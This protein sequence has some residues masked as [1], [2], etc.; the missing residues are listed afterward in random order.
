MNLSIDYLSMLTPA[1]RVGPSVP[2]D[3]LDA[4]LAKEYGSN[5]PWQ[6]HI[7]VDRM[8]VF[9]MFNREVDVLEKMSVLDL[10]GGSQ[11]PYHPWFSRISGLVGAKTTNADIGD[12]TGL[13]EPFDHLQ[14][15]L[16]I[17]GA[18]RVLPADSYDLVMNTSFL[19]PAGAFIENT[20]PRLLQ[21][22]SAKQLDAMRADIL[23]QVEHL[24][25]QD[26]L[27]AYDREVYRKDGGVLVREGALCDWHRS[28]FK[29]VP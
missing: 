27:Y 3:Q 28:Q 5:D 29:S 11:F 22:L 24:L 7:V 6:H 8:K 19:S 18:L 20:E 25:R 13:P 17:P 21:K 9:M 14:A 26:G 15:D 23:E 10:G 4:V 16:T 1:Q 2:L 12:P